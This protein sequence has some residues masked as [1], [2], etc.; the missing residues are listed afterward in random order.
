MFVH[1]FLFSQKLT[2]KSPNCFC[3]SGKVGNVRGNLREKIKFL[4]KQ[5]HVFTL[6]HACFRENYAK[7]QKK[8]TQKTKLCANLPRSYVIQYIQ[9]REN[10]RHFRICSVAISRKCAN[11][12]FSHPRLIHCKYPTMQFRFYLFFLNSAVWLLDLLPDDLTALRAQE[13]LQLF[14]LLLDQL[15]K[16]FLSLRRIKS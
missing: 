16:L 6:P 5:Q 9:L 2:R 11:E 14:Q 4:Q 10:V 7:R 13:L 8:L 12:F 3:L 15:V 1:S